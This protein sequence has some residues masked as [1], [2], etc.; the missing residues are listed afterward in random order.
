MRIRT[1][2]E[3]TKCRICRTPIPQGS[4]CEWVKGTPGVTCITPCTPAPKKPRKVTGRVTP[5]SPPENPVEST[6]T[7]AK[8]TPVGRVAC[9]QEG[10]DAFREAVST[11]DHTSLVNLHY[12]I[13]G[14]LHACEQELIGQEDRS[15]ENATP[16]L[17]APGQVASIV[18]PAPYHAECQRCG[19][20]FDCKGYPT[21][22]GFCD[23]TDLELTKLGG[24]FNPIDRHSCGMWAFHDAENTAHV[25]NCTSC[26]LQPRTNGKATPQPVVKPVTKP[27]AKFSF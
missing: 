19:H 21:K 26:Q 4:E 17:P 9:P 16:A 10:I 13:S 5:A 22:C 14:A 23:S 1:N 24:V 20:I 8:G 2:Y 3:N 6:R 15:P 25:R 12:I 18:Q 27:K 11:F 7:Q